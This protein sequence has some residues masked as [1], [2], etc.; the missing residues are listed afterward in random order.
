MTSVMPKVV[1]TPQTETYQTVGKPEMK[2]DAVKLVQGKPAFTADIE[3]R[4]MLHAKVLHSPHAH[5]RIKKI[6][7]SKAKSSGRRCG[8]ADLAGYSA[9]RLFHGG[10]I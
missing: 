7:T 6:D 1:V 4:G 10:T 2:V 5:A 8:G 3:K 9:R